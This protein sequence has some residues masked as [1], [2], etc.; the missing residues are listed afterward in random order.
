VSGSAP[1][2]SQSDA[3]WDGTGDELGIFA[4]INITPFTDVILVLLIV[5]MVSSSAMVDAMREGRIDVTLPKAGSAAQDSTPAP[6]LVVGLAADGRAY[7]HGKFVTEDE[8]KAVLR[9]TRAQEPK[10]VV[11]VDADGGLEHRNVVS[12]IDQVRAAGFDTVGIGAETTP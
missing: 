3:N 11:I 7:V 4:E 12:I 9:D 1:N 2:D 8:L 5:F 6:T 10:T